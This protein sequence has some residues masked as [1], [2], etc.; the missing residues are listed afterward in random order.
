MR[1]IRATIRS[2]LTT[3]L[4][5]GAAL[6]QGPATQGTT[7]DNTTF[8][9][10]SFP[11]GGSLDEYVEL[12]RQLSPNVNIAIDGVGSV[13]VPGVTFPRVSVP[14]AL[15][16]VEGT[17]DA[18]ARSLTLKTVRSGRDTS[19]VFLFSGPTQGGTRYVPVQDHQV[20]GYYIPAEDAKPAMTPAMISAAVRAAIQ[21]MDSTERRGAEYSTETGVL[22]VAGTRA[23]IAIAD[24]IVEA[25]TSGRRMA[26]AL[27]ALQARVDQL[28]AQVAELKR[29]AP[30]QRQP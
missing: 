21:K 19:T 17:R 22:T 4:F 8:I 5:A 29:A 2:V 20:K 18:I 12:V 16:W 10:I 30:A 23:D 26:V 13:K 6:A 3:S 11:K 14:A 9:R 1:T 25:M 24:Q 27:Q 28:T 7:V 15:Q